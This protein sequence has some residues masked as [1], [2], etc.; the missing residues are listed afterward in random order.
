VP[1]GSF[2]KSPRDVLARFSQLCCGRTSFGIKSVPP[3]GLD[4]RPVGELI[5]YR[6]SHDDVFSVRINM[7][8]I[9]AIET[10]YDGYRFRSRTEARYAHMWR[11]L[12]WPYEFE[13]Q[14]FVLE[15]GS[16]LPDFWLPG[17]GW[18]EVKGPPP[19]S[20]D[21]DRC[22]GLA[23]ETR[24]LVAL[25]SGQPCWGTVLICFS[26]DGHRFMTTLPWYL[27]QW[28]SLETI[29]IAIK[30]ARSVRFE[31]GETPKV[32]PLRLVSRQ[33]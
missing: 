3:P 30:A 11:T 12:Y 23:I 8:S 15:R 5:P 25:G 24:Q 27:M 28:V 29:A 20:E 4:R 10:H 18:F 32:V 22:Q 14:G 1:H 6:R 17:R 9:K 31:H 33:Q 26:P 16:Y 7:Y 13:R 21:E 2:W 19:T